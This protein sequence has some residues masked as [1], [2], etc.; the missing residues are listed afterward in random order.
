MPSNSFE[1][2]VV[3]FSQSSAMIGVIQS[4]SE[5]HLK[6]FSLPASDDLYNL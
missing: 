5:Q 3:L 2:V 4:S 1:I 6:F